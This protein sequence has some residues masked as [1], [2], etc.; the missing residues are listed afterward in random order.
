[1]DAHLIIS[2]YGTLNFGDPRRRREKEYASYTQ[3]VVAG[4]IVTVQ[5]A[6]P[7]GTNPTWSAVNIRQYDI[8]TGGSLPIISEVVGDTNTHTFY[9][10]GVV[11]FTA[12]CYRVV[13]EVTDNSGNVSDVAESVFQIIASAECGLMLFRYN[14]AENKDNTI[15]SGDF[16]FRCEA[17]F[18]PQNEKYGIEDNNFRDQEFTPSLLSAEAYTTYSLTVGGWRGVPNWV[19]RK[20]NLIFSCTGVFLGETG[21]EV[22]FIRSDGASIERRGSDDTDVLAVYGIDMEKAFSGVEAVK[23][24]TVWETPG[25][26]YSVRVRVRVVEAARVTPDFSINP[27]TIINSL[28]TS[29]SVNVAVSAPDNTWSFTDPKLGWVTL[30]RVDDDTVGVGISENG[31]GA[32]RTATVVFTWTDPSTQT[33]YTRILDIRQAAQAGSDAQAV[34]FSGIVTDAKT[35]APIFAS[36]AVRIYNN[37]VLWGIEG[38]DLDGSYTIDEMEFTE[39]QWNAAVF[40]Y[41][42]VVNGYNNLSGPLSKPAYAQAV[43]GRVQNDFAI[44]AI[45]EPVNNV[46]VRVTVIEA[47][48]QDSY[49]IGTDGVPHYFSKDN[50]PLSNFCVTGTS[51]SI[52]GATI[53]KSGIAEIYFGDSYNDEALLPERFLYQYTNLVS[54]TLPGG[55]TSIGSSVL[56]YC[57]ALTSLVIP[58]GVTSIGVYLCQHCSALASVRLPD[59][60]TSLGAAMFPSC[61]QLATLYCNNIDASVGVSNDFSFYNTPNNASRKRY[62]ATQ[63]LANA[64]VAKYPRTSAWTVVIT[65]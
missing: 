43:A 60:L 58:S 7:K 13:F 3:K 1:M 41:A 19:A 36:S 55:L 21:S 17:K 42:V 12:G 57:P 35:G 56:G 62:H 8:K 27:H 39:A 6:V 25:A 64:W 11:T 45:A 10:A 65:G 38:T 37:G 15:F 53:E 31:T 52:N 30:S 20:L 33:T 59:T 26:E 44:T 61:P 18:F 51:V 2:E 34:V 54:V 40:T 24:G 4:D 5:Y 29:G 16:Y 9:N 50:T 22:E 49:Y 14:N 48:R 28:G 47:Y 32:L 23:I 46:N 63:A